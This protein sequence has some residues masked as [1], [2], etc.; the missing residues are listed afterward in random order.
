MRR[1]QW[2]VTH[3]LHLCSQGKAWRAENP[4][5]VSAH[6]SVIWVPKSYPG[7]YTGCAGPL[8]AFEPRPAPVCGTS[9]KCCQRLT[10]GVYCTGHNVQPHSAQRCSL[11]CAFIDWRSL[12]HRASH[13]R[14]APMRG[15][16]CLA[17]AAHNARIRAVSAPIRPIA[18]SGRAS[19]AEPP[20]DLIATQFCPGNSPVACRAQ[21]AENSAKIPAFD[22]RGTSADRGKF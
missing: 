15:A 18:P 11:A 4:A 8:E 22:L 16:C 20:R 19:P 14:R 7:E 1:R 17:L 10:T 6:L 2:Y 21:T 13:K 3:S 5:G 12:S 9:H